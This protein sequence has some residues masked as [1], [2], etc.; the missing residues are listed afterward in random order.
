M[1]S[2]SPLL[3]LT[4]LRFFAA[5]SI[6][7]FHAA[8]QWGLPGRD[9]L[10][11]LGVELFFVL[12]GFILA[13]NYRTISSLADGLHIIG[14][15]IARIWP[16]HLVTLAVAF[17]IVPQNE[18]VDPA[19]LWAVIPL[20][21]TWLG[22]YTYALAGNS[23]SWTISVELAFYLLFPLLTGLS[24]RAVVAVTVLVTGIAVLAAYFF[25]SVPYV[26]DAVSAQAIMRLHPAAYFVQFA[27]GM[28]AC[29]FYLRRQW[30]LHI[31]LA[32]A[33][34]LG[35]IALALTYY[36]GA[37]GMIEWVRPFWPGRPPATVHLFA[38]ACAVL[39]FLPLILTLAIGQGLISRI[40]CKPLL[41]YLGEISFATYMCH[42]I[43]L[44]ALWKANLANWSGLTIYFGITLV[45]SAMLYHGIERPAQR[46]IRRGINSLFSSPER[47][48]SH[49]EKMRI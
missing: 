30:D 7:L 36:I 29:R 44:F 5:F 49:P 19:R 3:P 45:A 26:A 37:T 42:T 28:L 40:M 27:A 43:V 32:T 38:H 15:R 8:G 9:V 23:V 22:N 10:S 41:V 31:I 20:I 11:S 48:T 46:L 16:L 17:A 13:Y 33:L 18:F 6:V 24:S 21:Q 35:A 34:E 1:N 47:P 25:R 4:S 12:S 2:K 14:Y 39:F